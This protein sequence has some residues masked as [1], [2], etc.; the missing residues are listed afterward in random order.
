MNDEIIFKNP[1]FCAA[2]SNHP[3][4]H[5]NFR[6]FRTLQIIILEFTLY[7]SLLIYHNI[8]SLK[9]MKL[10]KAFNA[11]NGIETIG[12]G[13]KNNFCKSST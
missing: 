6:Y 1:L 13:D 3:E 7:E 8:L 5:D 10:D 12:K 11:V 4:K 9:I 2:H